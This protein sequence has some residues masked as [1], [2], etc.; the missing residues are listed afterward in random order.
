MLKLELSLE[1]LINLLHAEID[2]LSYLLLTLK[3][4]RKAVTDSVPSRLNEIRKEKEELLLK[5]RKLEKERFCLVERVVDSLGCT[6][7]DV[8]LTKLVEF[9]DEPYSSRLKN[10]YANLIEKVSHIQEANNFNRSLLQ[11]SL[12][13]VKDSLALIDNWIAPNPVYFQTG[14]IQSSGRSGKFLSGRI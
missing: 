9:V 13:L 5:M 14:E 11:H 3:T 1:K 12:K 2:T 6:I 7:D 4:E 10:C 8:K